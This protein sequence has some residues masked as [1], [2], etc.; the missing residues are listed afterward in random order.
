MANSYSDISG[1]TPQ[2]QERV[3]RMRAAFVAVMN[4]PDPEYPLQKGKQDFGVGLRPD[5]TL[6]TVT[7]VD[8]S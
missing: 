1:L 3:V 8:G 6:H 2:Q 7:P 5:G 4:E